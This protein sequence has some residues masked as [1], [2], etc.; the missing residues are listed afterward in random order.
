[1]SD[2]IEKSLR[3]LQKVDLKARVHGSREEL[4]HLIQT[5]GGPRTA[6]SVRQAMKSFPHERIPFIFSSLDTQLVL[7]IMAND[8][9]ALIAEMKK[10][11]SHP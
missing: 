5:L 11:K 6:E 1:M 7:D 3:G 2:E 9:D 8:V 10:K 4:V